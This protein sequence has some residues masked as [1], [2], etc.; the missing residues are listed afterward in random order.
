MS[1]PLRHAPNA[2]R[3]K[4][5]AKSYNLEGTRKVLFPL[6]TP[7]PLQP[8]SMRR[9]R[10]R[11]RKTRH[12]YLSPTPLVWGESPDL[13][14]AQYLGESGDIREKFLVHTPED[15]AEEEDVEWLERLWELY[16]PAEQPR[17]KFEEAYL[18]LMRNII[19]HRLE[20]LRL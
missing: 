4:K 19:D 8:P 20:Q 14:E 5:V 3:K 16:F 11:I 2:P 6:S 18:Q 15:V 1:S 13:I 12:F 7:P 9:R 17:N 10:L